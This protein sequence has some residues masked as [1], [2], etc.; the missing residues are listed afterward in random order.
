MDVKRDSSG[1]FAKGHS[2]PW[3]TNNPNLKPTPEL[4]YIIG[5]LK[6]DGWIQIPRIKG[7]LSYRLY[8][9]TKDHDFMNSFLEAIFKILNRRYSVWFS[10]R[11]K[12]DKRKYY[13]TCVYSKKLVLFL[14]SKD[15]KNVITAY[16]AEFI[17]GFADSEGTV[18]ER[19]I[20]LS[21]TNLVTLKVICSILLNVFKISSSI[22]IHSKG[23]KICYVLTIAGR[24]NL[25]L[26]FEK[27]G[28]SI[29]R[30]ALALKQVLASYKTEIIRGSLQPFSEEEKEFIKTNYMKLTDEKIARALSRSPFSIKG[31]RIWR[32]LKKPRYFRLNR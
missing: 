8:L 31:F 2:V 6:G 27:V 10:K 4:S 14:K 15:I 5:V 32:G 3:R 9:T 26:F 30:K 16:P 29:A 11:A 21:N 20:Y 13:T 7:I 12:D 22:R 25:N 28:F 23:K 24:K 18:G 17:K 19:C 1:R